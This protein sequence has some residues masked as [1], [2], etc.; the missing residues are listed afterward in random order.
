MNMQK[1]KVN[2]EIFCVW[3][4]KRIIYFKLFSVGQTINILINTVNN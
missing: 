2:P 1:P 3:N 4:C